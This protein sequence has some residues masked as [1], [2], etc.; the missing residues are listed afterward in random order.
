MHI[1]RYQNRIYNLFQSPLEQCI[2]LCYTPI[3]VSEGYSSGVR[4]FWIQNIYLGVI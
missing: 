4:N 3:S 1:E 2:S